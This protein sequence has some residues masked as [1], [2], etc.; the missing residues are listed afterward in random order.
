VG[1]LTEPQKGLAAVI[2]QS[3]MAISSFFVAKDT[4]HYFHPAPRPCYC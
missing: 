1:P 2:L 3:L 4:L